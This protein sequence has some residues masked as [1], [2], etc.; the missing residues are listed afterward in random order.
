MPLMKRTVRDDSGAWSLANI[1]PA[2]ATETATSGVR[3]SARGLT[4]TPRM[5]PVRSTTA[6]ASVSSAE[7]RR[8]NRQHRAHVVR[9][10]DLRVPPAPSDGVF[11]EMRTRP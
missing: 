1:A 2:R 6:A 5:F 4:Y 7:R 3:S 10:Q 11:W 8:R 9:R